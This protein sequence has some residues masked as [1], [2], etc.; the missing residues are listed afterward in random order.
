MHICCIIQSTKRKRCFYLQE[1]MVK[2]NCVITLHHSMTYHVTIREPK[3][4]KNVT[5]DIWDEYG[6]GKG[7]SEEGRGVLTTMIGDKSENAREANQIMSTA[8]MKNKRKRNKRVLIR[9]SWLN[10][11][12]CTV[13]FVR[14]ICKV[15][16]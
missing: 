5:E 8:D 4:G 16:K 14:L 13:V 10:Y 1:T 7:W 6:K 15:L 11:P 12:P 9:F 3:G 2:Q